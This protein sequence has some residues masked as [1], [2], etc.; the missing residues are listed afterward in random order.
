[1]C[2]P[3]SGSGHAGK[4]RPVVFLSEKPQAGLQ[5]PLG[6]GDPWGLGGLGTG[7]YTL[8]TYFWAETIDSQVVRRFSQAPP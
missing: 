7:T 2:L 4:P 1:M 8:L 5:G 3:V 6:G